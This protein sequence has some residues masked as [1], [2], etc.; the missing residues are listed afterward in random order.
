MGK[1][2]T[3]SQSRGDERAHRPACSVE[4]HLPPALS[5]SEWAWLRLGMASAWCLERWGACQPFPQ[6]SAAPVPSPLAGITVLSH[7]LARLSSSP[8]MGAAHPSPTLVCALQLTAQHRSPCGGGTAGARGCSC[9]R[10]D[11][12]PGQ[13]GSLLHWRVR[14]PCPQCALGFGVRCVLSGL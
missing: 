3:R 5:R 12:C 4:G 14:A 10:C 13:R 11:S 9:H 7:Q 1:L 2:L 6:H 8:D